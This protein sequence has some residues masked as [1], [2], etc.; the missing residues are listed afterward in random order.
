MEFVI[1]KYWQFLS[2]LGQAAMVSILLAWACTVF[3]APNVE[4]AGWITNAPLQGARQQHTAT[5]LQNGK[6]LIAGGTT[7]TFG[8]NRAELYDPATG[9]CTATGPLG[10][11][12][13]RHTAIVLRNGKV[14]VAGGLG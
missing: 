7:G 10:F 14:L 1:M 13:T 6:V 9:T 8:T 5:L 12:R 11:G 3:L 4:A 2:R